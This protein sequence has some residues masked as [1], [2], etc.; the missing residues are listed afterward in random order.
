VWPDVGGA[1]ERHVQAIVSLADHLYQL[2]RGID[3][4]W[5]WGEL[6]DHSVVDEVLA[7]YAGPICRP[8]AGGGGVTLPCPQPGSLTSTELRY[9]AYRHRFEV[10]RKG[11]T[12]KTTFRQPPQPSFRSV[13]YESPPSRFVYELRAS[14]NDSPLASWPLVA[15]S[16][17]VVCLRDAA[18]EKLRTALPA[19]KAEIERVLFGRKPD[20]TNDGPA[21]ERVRIIPLP[22]IGHPHADRAIRRILVEVPAGCSLR[23]DDVAWAFSGLEPIDPDTGEVYPVVLTPALS[24]DMLRHYGIVGEAR[25]RAWRTVTPAALPD[26]ASRRRIDPARKLTESKGGAERGQERQRAAAAVIQALRHV[27]VR[28]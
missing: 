10:E 3:M 1:D 21:R 13:A 22:S 27:D 9:Q 7:G 24:D 26:G 17:L 20:G 2:G 6:L 23:A 18:V 14:S 5:A 4:A 28:A 11:R 16:K 19:Q 12:V 25:A 8:S 15:V